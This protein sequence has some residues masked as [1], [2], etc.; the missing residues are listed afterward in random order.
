MADGV[1]YVGS[2]EDDGNLHAVNLGGT[3]RWS[4][5]IGGYI[6]SS[7]VVADRV[8]YVGGADS[9]LCAVAV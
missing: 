8:V 5:L 3:P 4:F 1:L 6:W 9:H 7:P 2:G